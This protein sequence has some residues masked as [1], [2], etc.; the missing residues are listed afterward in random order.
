MKTPSDPSNWECPQS[1]NTKL[2][3]ADPQTA[4][5]QIW[6]TQPN[7]LT[8]NK[9]GSSNLPN[10]DSWVLPWPSSQELFMAGI[11]LPEVSPSWNLNNTAINIGELTSSKCCL[12]GNF[13]NRFRRGYIE[14]V[15]LK[16]ERCDH[17][18][19]ISPNKE[20]RTPK[21]RIKK[22]WFLRNAFSFLFF[23]GRS[24]IFSFKCRS[25]PTR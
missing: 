19:K 8:G 17:A 1:M 12:E 13:E 5:T 20:Q 10:M 4:F 15:Q 3:T 14:R 16:Q 6:K 11:M 22:Y 23:W 2:T 7:A 25:V 9:T 21:S 18:Y 24:W